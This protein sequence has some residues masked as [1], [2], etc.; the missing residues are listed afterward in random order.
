[1]AWFRRLQALFEKKKLAREHEE[2]LAFHLAMREQLHVEEGMPRAEARREARRLFGNPALWRERIS[3]ID[4]MMLPQT[5]MQDVRYGARMLWRNASFTLVSILALAIGIGINTAVFTAYKAMIARSIDARDP[6]RVV[7]LTQARHSNVTDSLFSYPDYLAYRDHLHSFSGLVATSRAYEAVTLTGAGGTLS[8]RNAAADSLFGRLGMLPPIA[9]ANNAELASIFM[10]SENY[11]SVLGVAAIR[12]R[13]FDSEDARELTAAPGVVISDNYWHRRFGGAPFI[14]GKVIRLNGSAFTIIGVA[15]EDFVGT[16]I[17]APDF[18]FPISLES[19]VHPDDHSLRDRENRSCQLFGRLASGVSVGQAQAET[20]LFADHL[21]ALHDPKSELSK[22][23]L[24]QLLPGSPFPGKLPAGLRLSIA[25]VVAAAGMVLVI[26]CANV[27]SL[28]LARAAS[29]QNELGMRLSLGASR[30]RLIRQLLTESALLGMVAGAAAFLVTWALL[31]VGATVA[32]D[33]LPSD[34]GAY[35]V[36]VTPDLEIFAYVFVLSLC[37]GIL[38]G[39]TPALESARSALSSAIKANAATSPS[40]SRRLRGW[41]IGSQVAVSLVLMIASC[42]LVRS[43]IRALEMDTG[44]EGKRV[45]DLSFQFPEGMLYSSDKKLAIVRELRARIA[46]LPGVNGVTFGNPPDGSMLRTAAVSLNGEKPGTGN[47]R[48]YVDYSYV[49]ANYFETLDIPLLFGRH[50]H[51]QP[52]RPE[53]SAVVSESAARQLWPGQNP[54]GQQLRM[55]TEKQFYTSNDILPDGPAYRVIGVARDTRGVLLDGSD[56]HKIYLPLPEDRVQ[57]YPLLIRTQTDP[58]PFMS[59]LGSAIASVDPN[60]MVSTTTLDQMLRQ[61]EIFFAAS[62]S[63][64]IA[65]TIGLLGLV[66]ALMG[67]YSTVTYIVVLRTREVGL[68]MALGAK[69]GDILG[70]MLR[71]CVRPVLGGLLAGLALGVEASHLL[72]AVLYGLNTIDGISFGGVSLLFLAIALLAAY[73]PSRRA[74]R[75]QPVVALRC[76]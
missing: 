65:S 36:N 68:R 44:Y 60:L 30:L 55:S 72:R 42:M 67:I 48:A 71:D 50:F 49:Q 24:I 2:E 58:R 19:M 73:V 62:F 51:S 18:W 76:E 59:T 12:G 61:T 28:Q 15:P 32:K 9:I 56:S 14:L 13:T 6:G 20:G 4:M 46:A 25:L 57:G 45:V 3:E 10:V 33:A 7:S 54:I 11:F 34:M 64:A 69:K 70:L 35:I 37:A 40:R 23:A 17:A 26:A 53:A 31:A 21:S 29:R 16:G 8:Q 43:S 22:P 5:I 74:M 75:V 66:L 63:A 1:M 38:F 39:L 52:G 27:A 41:L 47:I